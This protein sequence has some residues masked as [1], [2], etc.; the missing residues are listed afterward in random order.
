MDVA[1]LATKM[2]YVNVMQEVNIS[3]MDKALDQVEQMGDQIAMMI[4]ATEV[5]PADV[6]TFDIRV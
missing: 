6:S 5:L 4:Q 3:M 2:A 1:A